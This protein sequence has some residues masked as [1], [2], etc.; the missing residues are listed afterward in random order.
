[1][2]YYTKKKV[3]LMTNKTRKTYTEEFK[4][5]AMKLVVEGK[6]S[7]PDGSKNLRSLP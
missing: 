3:Y 5:V 2:K 7:A 6:Q 1:L 4:A